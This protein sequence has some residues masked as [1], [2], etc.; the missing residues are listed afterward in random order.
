MAF[1]NKFDDA[2]S[3]IRCGRN[4]MTLNSAERAPLRGLLLLAALAAA[5]FLAALL[6]GSSRVGVS[7][8]LAALLGSGDPPTRRLHTAVPLPPGVGPVGVGRLPARS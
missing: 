1:S 7:R 2:N 6:I 8:S 3:L 5:V 4:G